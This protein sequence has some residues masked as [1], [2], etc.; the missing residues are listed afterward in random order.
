MS[1]L[2]GGQQST[3]FFIYIFA[4]PY[5]TPTFSIVWKSDL[6]NTFCHFLENIMST[7]C[8]QT[9][10]SYPPLICRQ[11]RAIL[12]SK[13]LAPGLGTL[14]PWRRAILINGPRVQRSK[15]PRSQRFEGSMVQGPKSLTATPPSTQHP[16]SQPTQPPK[17]PNTEHL[18]LT[19]SPHHSTT[20]PPTAQPPPPPTRPP[21]L[22][23]FRTSLQ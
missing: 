23:R 15:G 19:Q 22:H 2:L 5:D 13:L 11:R 14:L 21:E 1:V 6:S 20:Q 4:C 17:H 7:N 12:N 8:Q 9:C 18:P 16:T 3:S 10:E